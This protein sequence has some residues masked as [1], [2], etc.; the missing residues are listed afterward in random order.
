VKEDGKEEWSWKRELG[1]HFG[2]MSPGMRGMCA[3]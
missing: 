1:G 2:N 3:R